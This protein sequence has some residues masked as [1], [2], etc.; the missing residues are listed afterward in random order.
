[1]STTPKLYMQFGSRHTGPG[2]H[3][4]TGEQMA[5]IQKELGLTNVEM[6]GLLGCS[7]VNYSRFPTGARPIP[8]Y[9]ARASIATLILHEF[10]FL[11]KF[12]LHAKPY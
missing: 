7:L 11:R 4:M 1:M 8:A 2:K 12:K 9:I 5:A 6:A 10:D 3:S